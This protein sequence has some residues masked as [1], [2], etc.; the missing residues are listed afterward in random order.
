MLTLPKI[1]HRGSM[2][3]FPEERRPSLLLS[4]PSPPLE[5]FGQIRTL[6][7][8]KKP[9]INIY[10]R[11]ILD[12][13]CAEHTRHRP[14]LVFRLMETCAGLPMLRFIAYGFL[15]FATLVA[16]ISP[17]SIKGSKLYDQDGKQF[18]VKGMLLPK[19]RSLLCATLI[20][21]H[22]CRCHLRGSGRD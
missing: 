3:I 4:S 18:F 20:W 22:C 16:S 8:E 17:I 12:G 11:L 15:L 5:S 14:V 1:L 6:C 10:P 19:L 7:T 2:P 9:D 13:C 21:T